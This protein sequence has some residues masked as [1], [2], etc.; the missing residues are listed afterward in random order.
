LKS[1]KKKLNSLLTNNFNKR[2]K[3]IKSIKFFIDILFIYNYQ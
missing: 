2:K 3:K 1:T